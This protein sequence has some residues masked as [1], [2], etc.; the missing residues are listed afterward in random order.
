MH[1]WVAAGKEIGTRCR[2]SLFWYH[3][4]SCNITEHAVFSAKLWKQTKNCKNVIEGP[5]RKFYRHKVFSGRR[6]PEVQKFLKV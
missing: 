3:D 5:V 2:K 1:F 4:T 6:Q